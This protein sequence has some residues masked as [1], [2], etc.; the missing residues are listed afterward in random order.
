MNKYAHKVGAVFYG[1]WGMLHIVAAVNVYRLALAV[2]EDLGM[3]RARVMQNAWNLGWI[4]LFAIIVA[5]TMNWK[6]SRT[7]Y[8]LN[9]VVVSLADIGFLVAVV[10][11][12]A[13]PLVQGLI[14]PAVW[15]LAVLF[16]TIGIYQKK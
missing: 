11:P 13:L 16:S 2:P 4:A 12:G 14:G 7:G 15:V 8:W 9:L 1:L 3:V 6:N 5:I 10:L